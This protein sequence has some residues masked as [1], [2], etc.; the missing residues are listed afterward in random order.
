MDILI[1]NKNSVEKNLRI[2]KL[3]M[4]KLNINLDL[5]KKIIITDKIVNFVT[6]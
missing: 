6:K 3:S 4:Q 1:K 5:V 2:I